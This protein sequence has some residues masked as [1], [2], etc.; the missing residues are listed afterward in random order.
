MTSN[1]L[2]LRVSM[3]ALTYV[4]QITTQIYQLEKE[5]YTNDTPE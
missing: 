4:G 3:Q 5:H 1:Q 2:G